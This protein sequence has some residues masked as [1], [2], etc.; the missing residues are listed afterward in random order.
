[1]AKTEPSRCNLTAL[2]KAT[3]RV[4]QLYDQVLA[5]SGLRGTQRAILVYVRRSGAPTMGELAAAL[6]LD[7]TALNHNL[8]PL[9]RDGLLTITVD[10]NDRRSRLVR[11]TKRG[12]AMLEDS[13][14]AWL[15]AQERFE[16]AFGAR[17]AADLRQTLELIASLEFDERALGSAAS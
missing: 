17:Q 10:K 16:S 15:K 1:M 4:S 11:L 9:E 3:R 6:V 5:A 8:K 12:E 13:Q 7:R 14:A 2:R